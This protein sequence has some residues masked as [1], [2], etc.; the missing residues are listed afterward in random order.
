MVTFAPNPNLCGNDAGA[1]DYTVS[2]G[3]G[4]TDHRSRDRGRHVRG[5]PAG[6]GRRRRTVAEDWAGARSTCCANDT[7]VENDPIS[8]ISVTQPNGRSSSR[9]SRYGVTYAPNANSATPGAPDA[10]TFTYTVPGGV[11]ATVSMTVTCVDDP[12]VAVNDSARRP[13]TRGG[14]TL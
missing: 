7:D 12:P 13:R 1:F 8:V 11:T 5:R 14:Q 3:H 9:S 10:D 2:D 6:R 4:G